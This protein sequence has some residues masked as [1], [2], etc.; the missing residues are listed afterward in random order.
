MMRESG[1]G[2]GGHFSKRGFDIAEVEVIRT[3]LTIALTK[4]LSK[5]VASMEMGK[6]RDGMAVF[7]GFSRYL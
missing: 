1:G 3:K 5:K 7:E 4:A 6:T 2:F